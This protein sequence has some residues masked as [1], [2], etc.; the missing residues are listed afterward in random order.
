MRLLTILFL[1]LPLLS[2]AGGDND[3]P[4]A[5]SAGLANAGL[6][7]TDIWSIYHNQAGLGYIQSPVASVFYQNKF[8]IS[9]FAYAGFAGALPLGNG[10][11][12]VSYTN[13]GYSA[14]NEGKLGLAYGMKLSDRFSV[15]VQLNYHS[16]R[17]NADGYGNRGA[18]SADV[19]FRLQVSERVSLAA[20]ITNPTRTKL[21]DFDDERIPTLIRFGGAYQI[22]DDLMATGEVEKDIDMKPTFRAGVEYQPVDIL[23]LRIGASSN[24]GLFAFG[25]GL[26]LDAFK[27][28]LSTTYH[29]IL[30]YSPQIALTYAPGKK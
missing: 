3:P 17:I 21:N 9:D 26:N 30:G 4:G 12:G 2:F 20:H 16:I 29:S 25:F 10:S 22:S 8:L 24:P 5:R 13:F 1:C 6:N 19:G 28:D 27:L 18:L 11:I 14:Y 23:F 7:F 15:G